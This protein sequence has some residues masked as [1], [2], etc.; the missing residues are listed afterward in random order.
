MPLSNTLKKISLLCLLATA[1]HGQD[2]QHEAVP[3]VR[4][5]SRWEIGFTGA[6]SAAE[7]AGN[8]YARSRLHLRYTTPALQLGATGFFNHS[9]EF[10]FLPPRLIIQVDDADIEFSGETRFTARPERYVIDQPAALFARFRHKNLTVRASFAAVTQETEREI[11]SPTVDGDSLFFINWQPAQA[12]K[13]EIV[14]ALAAGLQWRFLHVQAGAA[15][16]ALL[17]SG[18]GDFKYAY[19]L[20]ATPF[21]ALIAHYKA[22]RLTTV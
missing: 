18:D 14:S 12:K 17:T 2:F 5:S 15:N 22:A 4:H 6:L 10:A 19:R 21:F 3:A 16:L 7:H 9:Q 20:Q 11:A 13:S 8:Q 1:V